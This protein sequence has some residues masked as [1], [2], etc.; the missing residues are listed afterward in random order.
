[1]PVSYTALTAFFKYLFIALTFLLFELEP[2]SV[3]ILYHLEAD[4]S[5]H[6]MKSD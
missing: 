4:F 6:P 5:W 3:F 2:L 1:M